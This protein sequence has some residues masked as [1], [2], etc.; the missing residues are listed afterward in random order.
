MVVHALNP[1]AVHALQS[2]TFLARASGVD[3]DRGPCSI[4]DRGPGSLQT[5]I[6]YADVASVGWH[7]LVILIAVLLAVVTRVVYL[8]LLK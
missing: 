7:S 3:L 8:M 5:R 2:G 6:R 4:Q 1:G